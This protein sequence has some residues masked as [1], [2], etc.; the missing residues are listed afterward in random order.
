MSDS[1]KLL[2]RLLERILME[3][4]PMYLFLVILAVN[5]VQTLIILKPFGVIE[6][7]LSI[8]TR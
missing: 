3:K 8:I 5:I 4:V 6:L 1:I 7:V 2:F